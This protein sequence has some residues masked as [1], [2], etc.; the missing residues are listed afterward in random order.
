MFVAKDIFC[1]GYVKGECRNIYP[2]AKDDKLESLREN[3]LQALDNDDCSIIAVPIPV[4]A[5]DLHTH[6]SRLNNPIDMTGAL[7]PPF[8]EI[9]SHKVNVGDYCV[10]AKNSLRELGYEAGDDFN[11]DAENLQQ[12]I[13][14]VFNFNSSIPHAG[15]DQVACQEFDRCGE[16]I[17]SLCFQTAQLFPD[18][19]DS[20]WKRANA[21]T[22]P[23]G[24]NGV[25][26]GARSLREGYA[27]HF[28]PDD[29]TI[30]QATYTF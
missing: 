14:R 13:S 11:F 22:D 28:R 15:I 7:R 19:V 2:W 30:H 27:G 10:Q 4:G 1:N 5:L 23:F 17:N 3:P 25:Y 9:A 16:S 18:G 8:G 26:E 20:Q 12:Y 29:R 24:P 21:N 6:R